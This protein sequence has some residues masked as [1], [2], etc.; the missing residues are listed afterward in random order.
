MKKALQALYSKHKFNFL[1][2]TIR[3]SPVLLVSGIVV[4]SEAIAEF[5]SFGVMFQAPSE[6][7]I[8]G[9]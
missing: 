3:I 7:I 2:E 6:R 4:A 8:C 9:C 1:L 5:Q